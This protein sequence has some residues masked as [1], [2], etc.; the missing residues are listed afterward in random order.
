MEYIKSLPLR[1][2]AVGLMIVVAPIA[3]VFVMASSVLVFL[4]SVKVSIQGG[5]LNVTA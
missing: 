1:L 2:A 3:A 4:P 5:K